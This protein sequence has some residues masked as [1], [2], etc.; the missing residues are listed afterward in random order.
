MKLLKHSWALILSLALIY[1]F[2]HS[3]GS[4]P[5]LG[6]L[7]SPFV[8]FLQNTKN[9]GIPTNEELKLV[10][11]QGKVDVLYDDNGVPHIFAE[12]DA[13]LY[14]AQGYVIARDR[15]WQME[16]YTLVAGGRLTE[17][18]GERAL[19]YDRYNRRLGMYKA[20]QEI[21]NN[22]EKDS[23]SSAILEKYAAG[24]N[25]YIEE[26]SDAEL[27]I[28]YKILDYKPEKWSKYKTILML[29]NM[30]N[31]LNGGST[32]YRVSNVAATYGMDIIRE[33]FT[34]YPFEESPIIPE[35][36]AWNFT[37]VPTPAMPTSPMAALPKNKELSMR[38][39]EPRP[40]IG[41]NNWAVAGEKS[42]TGLPI[43]ANDPHLG[44]SLPSIWYQ[45]QLSSPSVNVY[46]VAL[47]GSPGVIIGFNKDIAWGVT[48]VGSDVMD[49]YQIKF[50]DDA[51]KEYWHDNQ[52]KPV[53]ETVEVYRLKSGK[54]IV[55]TLRSTHHG[56]I[57]YEEESEK[58][59]GKN[60]P[61]GHAMR[62]VALETDGSDML[63]FHYLN[64][65]KNHDDYKKALTY[66]TAPAQ[67][68][69]FASN[70]NDI[71]ITPNG[72]LPLKWQGQGKFLLDGTDPSHDWQGWIPVE[73]NPTV[74]NPP[75]GFVSSANQHSVD[76]TY[77]YYL[78]W[79]FAPSERGIRINERLDAMT[80]AT[81][82]SLRMLQN[83]N[84]SVAARR[85]LPTLLSILATDKEVSQLPAYQ[86]LANWDKRNEAISVGATIF[87]KWMEVLMYA[88]WEDEF[89]AEKKNMLYPTT[90]VTYHLLM[91]KP[92]A[93]WFDNQETKGKVETR[94]EIVKLSFKGTLDS[95]TKEFGT[96]DKEKW[97]WKNVKK[98]EIAHLVPAFTSFGRYNIPNGG[99]KW[100][101]NAT[102]TKTGP[103]WRMVVAV[104]KGWPKGFGLYPG[105][106]SG[107]PA[108]KYY[109]NMIDKWANGEL[110]ELLFL[111][112]K[113]EAS[114]RI[115]GK[116]SLQ[117]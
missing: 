27:P 114:P 23:L 112:S 116:L 48:N 44:L 75:R 88:I 94:D 24:V 13:D 6:K 100:I 89:S 53:Q 40:E 12:N 59:F 113:E 34:D 96:M 64:R 30:R 83:D 72:K 7:F 60:A 73:Q 42:A 33:L 92:T 111:K 69:I 71:A 28:E 87:E 22:L 11:L 104:D 74:K 93:K 68:F 58:N 9:A 8:G 29:M 110:Q 50:K 16:F 79:R 102:T 78:G 45:M 57:I 52:W 43:L 80:K 91:N 109:D 105:G 99:G 54:E 46:G 67:N 97:A 35:G 76:P 2:N 39:E 17:V 90:D 66:Y 31:T 115:I 18:V 21:A 77:P 47:P 86:T 101:V 103:S 19:E 20:A 41:S 26:L 63:T 5:P 14:Q 36:T 82:D 55:D 85:I 51:K 98:T 49:F 70:Q 1:T 32:D 117:N 3:L 38:I 62:W 65:A 107:N 108:S 56:P 15:L 95:L 61:A 106:Q 4:I 37:P 81:P 25:A 84:F 10:G